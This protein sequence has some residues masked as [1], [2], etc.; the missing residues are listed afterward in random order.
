LPLP[1]ATAPSRLAGVAIALPIVLGAAFALRVVAFCTQ[2]YVLFN[3]E[4]FQYFEQG[5]RLAFGTGVV[6]WEFVDGIRSWLLP[7]LIAGI[8]RLT[9]LVGDDP[10]L[11]VRLTRSLCAALSLVV[12]FAG[13]RLGWRQFGLLGAIVT[14]GF[15]A[16]WFDLIYF[17]PAVLT[18]VIAAHVAIAA[19]YLG[20]GDVDRRRLLWAGALFGLAVCL[21][22]QYGPALLAAALVQ[23]RL[24]WAR[25]RFVLLGGLAVVVPVG[26]VLDAVTLGAPFQSI[27][28]NVT[29]NTLDHVSS[30]MGTK[31][32]DYYLDY[33]VLTLGPAAVLLIVGAV[34]MPALAVAAAVTLLLHSLVPHKEVRFIYLTIAAAPIL[35]G[36]GAAWLIDRLTQ[37]RQAFGVGAATLFLMLAAL[38]SWRTGT[39]PLGSRWQVERA[40]VEATLA[41]HAEPAMCG[42]LVRDVW[43]WRSGGYTYLNRDVPLWYGYYDPNL[44]LPH[45]DRPEIVRV[46]RDGHEVPQFTLDRVGAN[47]RRFSHMIAD[48]GWQEPGY[49][50]VACFDDLDRADD[51]PPLCLYRRPGGCSAD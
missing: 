38:L 2:T 31:G 37:G 1:C 28:L 25:W 26:G 39:G 27:W 10:L 8:M 34:R 36:S 30:G 41:A 17:S 18:E 7:G 33:L 16:I 19:I 40:S 15:C 6:P 4:T 46:M 11:Y 22:F 43:F 29:R 51:E 48:Q 42:L 9:A 35:I 45:T 50:Q 13:F 20:H 12:V 32:A 3:D 21:R 14:G 23:H 47:T 49:T 5:H 44:K 24:Y